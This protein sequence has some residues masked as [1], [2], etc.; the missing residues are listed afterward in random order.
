[1]VTTSRCSKSRKTTCS[2]TH[3]QQEGEIIMAKEKVKIDYS[4]KVLEIQN[5]QQ[6]FKTGFGKRRIIN[7]AVDG[8][9]FDVYKRESFGLVGESGCGKTT[10]G[11]TII[12][13]YKPTQGLVKLNGVAVGMGYQGN[14]N[15]IKQLKKEF[16][17]EFIKQDTFKSKLKDLNDT[18]QVEKKTI[19]DKIQALHNEGLKTF[20]I[21]QKEIDV[22]EQSIIDLKE[23]HLADVSDLT[24]KTNQIILS[25]I[26]TP[27]A[28]ERKNFEYKIASEKN[29]CRKKVGAINDSKGLESEERKKQIQALE[30]E[31]D[32]RIAVF[33]QEFDSNVQT[34]IETDAQ[35]TERVNLVKKHKEEKQIKVSK[36]KER[37]TQKK[38]ELKEKLKTLKA[39]KVSKE[40]PE[41]IKNELNAL[42]Q[43]LSELDLNYKK[44]ITDLKLSFKTNIE[45][46]PVDTQAQEKI[47]QHY[48]VL[49]NKEKEIIKEAHAVEN[50]KHDESMNKMQ[51]IFQDPISSLN[52]RMTVKEIIAE[53]LRIQGFKDDEVIN[54][55]VF[56]V[57]KIVG[58]VPEHAFRYPHEF[59]GGQRQRI[60]IARALIVNPD[61]IIADEPI[62]A[63]DVSIQAQIINLMNELK[64]T[65]GLTIL[66]IAHDLSVVKYFCDRIAVMYYG[67]IV[68]LA[69]A[70]ELFKNP[71]HPYTK[72][73][74]SAVPQPDPITERKRKR[75]PYDPTLHDYSKDTPVLTEVSKDHFVLA[76]T[77]EIKTYKALLKS[78]EVQA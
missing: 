20:E 46:F 60:G 31:R 50:M 27:E 45:S 17:N 26:N 4:Q 73:L 23:T 33:K 15:N 62:S 36:E 78:S 30:E 70:E 13:L 2:S 5:L 34:L 14:L 9:T 51:M 61:F 64:K 35:K 48:Q 49:I 77:K 6:H 24:F 59:S 7:K 68:E 58:L 19:K 16:K 29:K 25:L 21:Y 8:V 11:R 44:S 74:L 76:N 67:K 56:D 42:K 3:I 66:F 38:L 52:P 47:K 18:Y 43:T 37:Y 10:L 28:L 54:Q 32:S 71:M 53:G 55:K 1:M 41:N 57:L 75:I 22:L 69:S 72:S 65:L 12:K 63:L 40:L 39:A